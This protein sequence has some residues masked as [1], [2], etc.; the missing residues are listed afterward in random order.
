MFST[1]NLQIRYLRLASGSGAMPFRWVRTITQSDS[2]V[3]RT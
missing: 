1:S 3:V 2:Y